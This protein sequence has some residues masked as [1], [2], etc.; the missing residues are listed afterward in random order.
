MAFTPKE[1]MEKASKVL[2]KME[3]ILDQLIA[4][5]EKLKDISLG[6]FSE[7]A[8]TP[9]QEKQEVLAEQLNALEKSF[10]ESEKEGQETE[11]ADVGDR[12]AKKLRYF[13]H[14]NAVFIENITE[15]N[16]MQDFLKGGETDVGLPHRRKE[17]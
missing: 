9:L 13:Q 17:D 15:G 1:Y 7:E 2:E 8:V 4:N 3:S 6:N 11:L 10:E 14:L 5:A 12:L 16:F